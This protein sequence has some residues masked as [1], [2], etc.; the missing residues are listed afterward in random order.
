MSRRFIVL[1]IPVAAL[2]GGLIA[3]ETGFARRAFHAIY[4]RLAGVEVLGPYAV[5]IPPENSPYQNW[6]ARERASLPVF[7][8]WMVDDVSSVALRPWPAMGDGVRGLYLR[9]SDYQTSD[10]RILELPVGGQTAV[11]R[12]FYEQGVYFISG[13]GHTIIEQEGELAQRVSWQAGSLFSVPLNVRHQHFNDD[14]EP[15]RLLVVTSFPFVLNATNSER[16][17]D[18]SGFAF[19]DRYDG[20]EDYLARSEDVA[21][22]WITTNFVEDVLQNDMTA[23]DLRGR[24]NR[25]MHWTMAGNSM[26]SLHVSEFPPGTY[27]KAHRHSNDAF[28]LLLSGEGYSVS[29]PGGRYEKRQRVDWRRGTL[30]APPTYWYHQHLNP[31]P[32]PARYLS[33]NMPDLLLNLGLRF[34]DQLESPDDEVRQEWER[35]IAR[36]QHERP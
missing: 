17:I 6:L 8:G 21:P 35:E 14:D 19:T 11:Q 33:I 30:F 36:L 32:T 15:V 23:T 22:E 18:S 10:A 7:E 31:G 29:W 16:F 13:P 9:L 4:E 34:T 3:L 5:R 26:L 12:H 28:I 24:G 27:K 1:L 2:L 25:V 20:A